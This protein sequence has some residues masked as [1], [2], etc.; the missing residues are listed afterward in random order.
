MYNDG[1]TLVAPF[2]VKRLFLK[3]FFTTERTENTEKNSL[4]ISVDSVISVVN[5][6]FYDSNWT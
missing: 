1:V 3:G 6:L 2:F 5:A 4:K